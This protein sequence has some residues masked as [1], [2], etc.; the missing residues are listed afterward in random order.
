MS[1]AFNDFLK[2][3]IVLMT[4]CLVVTGIL[5]FAFNVTKP[6]ID[7]NARKAAESARMELLPE[8]DAFSKVTLN[9]TDEIPGFV[10]AYK[11]ENGAGIVVTTANRGYGGL[12]KAMISVDSDGKIVGIKIM[13][14]QE[15]PGI[16]S[17]ALTPEH[18]QKYEGQG[19][20]DAVEGITGVT[21][22][23]T[24]MR[25]NVSSALKVFEIMNEEGNN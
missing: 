1:N 22:T 11:A 17:K 18:L 2:P 7:E 14:N 4:I 16:G 23:S 21:F 25:T 12:V 15:T 6:I 20:A 24:A 8:G 19:S 9:T 3:I 10:D 5:A 13:E